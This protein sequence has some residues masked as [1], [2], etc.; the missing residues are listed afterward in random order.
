MI[1]YKKLPENIL[2][3]IPALTQEC[4][5]IEFIDAFFLFGSG[6]RGKLKPLSDLDFAILLS[7]DVSS[8]KFLEK[9]LESMTIIE[10]FLK[11]DEFDLVILNNA[12]VRFAHKIL[13]TGKLLFCKNNEHLV[14]FIENNNIRYLDFKFYRKQYDAIFLECLGYNGT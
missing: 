3:K 2:A 11:T 14:S 6:A 1:K 4:S 9:Q 7:A 12:P 10:D 5:E 13:K 8:S